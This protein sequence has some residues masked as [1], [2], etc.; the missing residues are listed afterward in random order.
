M[1][2]PRDGVCYGE[3]CIRSTPYVGSLTENCTQH[4]IGIESL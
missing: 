4:D 3:A 1:G 2:L